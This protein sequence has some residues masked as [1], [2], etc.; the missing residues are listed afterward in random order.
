MKKKTMGMALAYFLVAYPL[1]VAQRISYRK[2]VTVLQAE[3]TS[4][5]TQLTNCFTNNV[6]VSFLKMRN[7]FASDRIE[8]LEAELEASVAALRECEARL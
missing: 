8:E 1:S 7:R 4:L 2:Q 6:S 5:Q 3:N